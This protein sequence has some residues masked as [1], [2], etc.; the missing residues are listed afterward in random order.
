MEG[1]L[2]RKEHNEDVFPGNTS[3]DF[4]GMTQPMKAKMER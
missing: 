1:Y 3:W 2:R 4:D